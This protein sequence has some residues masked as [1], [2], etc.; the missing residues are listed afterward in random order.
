MPYSG[1]APIAGLAIHCAQSIKL[2]LKVKCYCDTRNI[3]DAFLGLKVAYFF[4]VFLCLAT[5]GFVRQGG[6]S[7]SKH[8]WQGCIAQRILDAET[9][10]SH[11]DAITTLQEITQR[12]AGQRPE[13]QIEGEPGSPG[14]KQRFRAVCLIGGKSCGMGRGLS[15]KEAKQAAALE[16]LAKLQCDATE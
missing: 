5:S 7:E 6:I 12:N 3:I 16:A 15:K 10:E 9:V 8:F 11:I 14:H 2:T 4:A 13:F 1:T